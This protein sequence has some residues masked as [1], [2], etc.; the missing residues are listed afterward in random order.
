METWVASTFW[1]LCIVL[2]R[3]WM[4]F[5]E[6]L[7]QIILNIQPEVE[8][9][10]HMAILFN[11]FLRNHHTVFYST[12]TTRVLISLPPQQYIIFVFLLENLSCRDLSHFHG[13]NLYLYM[14]YCLQYYFFFLK[15]S[16]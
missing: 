5:L 11:I 6:T 13:N 9:L 14:F 4:H 15:S 7:L 12:W 2:L 3:T 8:L 16:V 10:D 1:I